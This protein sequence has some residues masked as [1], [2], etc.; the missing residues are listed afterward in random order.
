MLPL[1]SSFGLIS[2]FLGQLQLLRTYGLSLTQVD[3]WDGRSVAGQEDAQISY[4]RRYAASSLGLD[5]KLSD[6]TNMH[7]DPYPCR[8]VGRSVAVPHY[9]CSSV[10]WAS[11]KLLPA[12]AS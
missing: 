12:H 9:F 11:D 6:M 7:F 4:S 5:T 1:D 3:V 8:E 2:L 10:G